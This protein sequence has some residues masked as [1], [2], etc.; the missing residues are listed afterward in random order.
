[1]AIVAMAVVADVR[2]PPPGAGAATRALQVVGVWSGVEQQ[3]FREV[4]DEFTHETGITVRYTSLG[5]NLAVRLDERIAAGR[6]PDVA[7]LPQPGLLRRLAHQHRLVALDAS[8]RDV[9]RQNFALVWQ[10]LG[11]VAGTLYGVWFKAANKSLVWYNIGEFER[12]GVVPPSD[13]RGLVELGDAFAQRGVAAF[14]VGAADG[15]TLTDWF[16]NIYMRTAGP[17]RYNEL[18]AHRLPWTDRSVKTALM[19]MGE[20]L[21]PTTIVGGINGALEMKFEDSVHAASGAAPAAAM[22]FEGDFVAGLLGGV[23]ST[24]GVDMDVFP[25]PGVTGAAPTVIGGGDA[26]VLLRRSSGGTA[27]L[28]FLAGTRAPQIWASHG[29]FVSPNLNVDLTAYPDETTRSIARRVIEAGNNF[30]FDLSDQAPAAFGA[31]EGEGMRRVLQDFL[32]SRD[33]D[34]TAVQLEHDARAAYGR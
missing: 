7:M 23:D 34:A 16:E 8:V 28:R 9:V 14:S 22:V 11:S 13:L 32:V 5:R 30:R 10:R 17:R 1:M 33:V 2:G 29:G 15:W 18:S 25:F 21:A 4:L 27:L 26:A 24:I 3:R 31:V 12:L 19:T 20:L 6:A